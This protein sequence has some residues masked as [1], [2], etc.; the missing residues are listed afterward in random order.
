M[1]A[2]E[3]DISGTYLRGYLA[4]LRKI[5]GAQY[6]KLLEQAGFSQFTEHY[7]A[8]TFQPVIKGAQ[9]IQ[10]NQLIA[11]TLGDDL[12]NLFQRNLGREFGKYAAAASNALTGYQPL[13]TASGSTDL[14]S[15][16]Q[17][18]VRVNQRSTNEIIEVQP[19]PNSDQVLLIYHNCLYCAGR[20]SLEKPGCPSIVAFYKELLQSLTGQRVTLTETRCGAMHGEPDCYFTVKL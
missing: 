19:D 17:A 6:P 15:L 11:Q 7:P 18:I 5:T 8:A 20:V 9:L 10:L 16:L 3:Y 4:G 1:S 12:F 2:E 14:I 13:K